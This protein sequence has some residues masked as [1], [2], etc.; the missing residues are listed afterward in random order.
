M[1]DLR[2]TPVTMKKNGRLTTVGKVKRYTAATDAKTMRPAAERREEERSP[3]TVSVAR[4]IY[5][6][7]KNR[8]RN[9]V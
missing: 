3:L 9:T 4:E 7:M 1:S 2:Q 8:M 6:D 5:K